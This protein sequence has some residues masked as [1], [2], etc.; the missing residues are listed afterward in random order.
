[1]KCQT[2]RDARMAQNE[3]R[4]DKIERSLKTELHRPHKATQQL[5]VF[6]FLFQ[7]PFLFLYNLPSVLLLILLL[8][9]H[10]NLWLWQ[11]RIDAYFIKVSSTRRHHSS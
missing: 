5:F 6:S 3:L 7:F 11:T 2:E 4:E 8:I 10:P 1:M 9:W